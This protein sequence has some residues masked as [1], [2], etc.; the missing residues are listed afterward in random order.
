ML[1]LLGWYLLGDIGDDIADGYL[2]KSLYIY[3]YILWQKQP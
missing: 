2:H 3:I 1:G